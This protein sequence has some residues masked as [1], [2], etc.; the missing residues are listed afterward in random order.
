MRSRSRDGGKEM[1]LTSRHTAA[2]SSHCRLVKDR[3]RRLRR[4]VTG[5][6]VQRPVAQSQMFRYELLGR[7][8]ATISPAG[9]EARC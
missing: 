7:D 9:V 8:K 4:I 3:L 2:R 5:L 1:S 6:G